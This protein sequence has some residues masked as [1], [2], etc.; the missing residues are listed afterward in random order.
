M[1]KIKLND[2]NEIPLLGLGTYEIR[3]ED[4]SK[5]I[6]YAFEAGYRHID[7]AKAYYNEEEIG[8]CFKENFIAER[9]NI[10]YQQIR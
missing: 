6:E 9:R 8:N 4:V 7:T 1:N 2:G 5:S 10:Y 3:G